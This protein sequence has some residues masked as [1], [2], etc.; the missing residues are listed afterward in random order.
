MHLRWGDGNDPDI[1]GLAE[2]LSVCGQ[3]EIAKTRQESTTESDWP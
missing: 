2:G 3:T 1:K